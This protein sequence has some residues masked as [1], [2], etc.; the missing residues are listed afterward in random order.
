MVKFSEAQLEQSIIELFQD[1]GYEYVNGDMLHRKFDEV[2][3][4]DDMKN[5]LSR[6]YLDINDTE[7]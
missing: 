3:L 7:L 5:F 1:N 6:R 4:E 2:L